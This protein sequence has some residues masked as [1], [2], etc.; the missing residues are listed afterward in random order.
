MNYYSVTKPV[1]LSA[2][3]NLLPHI[4]IL[5]AAKNDIQETSHQSHD[6]FLYGGAGDFDIVFVDQDIDFAANAKFRQ[7]DAGFD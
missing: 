1:I 3:K 2:A 5:S 4:E 7:V 6:L